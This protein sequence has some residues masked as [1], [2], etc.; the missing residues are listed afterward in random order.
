[1]HCREAEMSSYVPSFRHD[2]RF[3]RAEDVSVMCVPP[4]ASGCLHEILC[5]SVHCVFLMGLLVAV[6]ADWPGPK[7]SNGG[8]LH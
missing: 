1:M 8:G 4:C 6:S 7:V 3:R 2:C 5:G